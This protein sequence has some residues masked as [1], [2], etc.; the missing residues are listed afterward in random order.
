MGIPQ[1]VYLSLTFITLLLSANLHGSPR[2]GTVNLFIAL[3][4]H[5]LNIGLLYWGGFFG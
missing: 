5:A 1:I 2:K 4:V 3:T